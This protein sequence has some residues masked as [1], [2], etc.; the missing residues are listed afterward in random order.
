M[1]FTKEQFIDVFVKYNTSVFPIQAILILLACIAIVFSFKEFSFS[2]I[3]I[4]IILA[5]FWLWIGVVYHL[6]FFA[7]I[8]KAAYLFGILYIIQSILFFYSGVIKDRL[9]FL[10]KPDKYGILGF[11]FIL[12]GLIFYPILNRYLGHSYPA[13]PTFGL[14]CPTTIFTFGLLMWTDRTMPKY[15]LFIPLL[16]SFLGFFAALKYG[17]YADIGLLIAGVTAFTIL[18]IR[19]SKN[20]VTAAS[21]TETIE[22]NP[23]GSK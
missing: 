14:P 4:S 7:R 9:N 20:S 2:N 16:W 8:N 13:S 1:P 22:E 19:N 11:I 15:I 5:F 23:N 18:I 10:F 21:G 17:I 6:F 12:Y 3:Y